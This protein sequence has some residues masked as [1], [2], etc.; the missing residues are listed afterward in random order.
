MQANKTAKAT[1]KAWSQA[2]LLLEKN[3]TT[4]WNTE[5]IKSITFSD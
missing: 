2:H 1:E 4:S 3:E 5:N